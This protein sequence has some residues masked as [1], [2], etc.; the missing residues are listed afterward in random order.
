[1]HDSQHPALNQKSTETPA[2]GRR[3]LILV[4]NDDGITAGGIAKLV[5]AV[6]TLG[7][8]VVVAPDSPQSGM[9]HAITVHG[10]I[11]LRPSNQ[12]GPGVK[13]YECSGTPADCVKLAKR[14]VLKGRTPDLVVS[15]INHGANSSISII[16]SGT[17]SAAMEAAIE[18]VPAI[19]FSLCEFG[20]NA[21][22]D[23]AVEHVHHIAERVLKDGLPKGVVLNVNI[24]AH[25]PAHPIKGYMV[26][27]QGDGYWAES[28]QPVEGHVSENGEEE[29]ILEGVFVDRDTAARDTDTWALNNGYISIVP[30]QYDLTAYNQLET[31]RETWGMWGMEGV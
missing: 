23:H 8:V 7:E 6:A 1:M 15:G 9:G 11:K 17:M 16:Y 21:N 20:A 19:G 28:F 31:M 2:S 5:E 29:V 22:F 13:A 30:A 24:P 4:S 3:P 27:R 18:W 25:D 12:F 26:C 14:H 10:S